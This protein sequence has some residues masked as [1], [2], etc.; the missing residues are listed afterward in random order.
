MP[1]IETQGFGCAAIVMPGSV[2][3]V[4]PH[5]MQVLVDLFR[6]QPYYK[7]P[8]LTWSTRQGPSLRS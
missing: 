5:C 2:G 1:E 6:D 8:L 4:M 3:R 7:V